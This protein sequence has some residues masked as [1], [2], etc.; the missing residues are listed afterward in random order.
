LGKGSN[1]EEIRIKKGRRT[2][3]FRS[4]KNEPFPK[5]EVKNKN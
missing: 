3:K 4:K 1:K 5:H 2:R